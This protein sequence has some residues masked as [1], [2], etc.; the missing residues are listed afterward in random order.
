MTTDTDAALRAQLD[1]L[2]AHE[3]A[4]QRF[5]A[6][7]RAMDRLD[8]ELLAAQFWPDAEVDY[9]VFYKGVIG[10][11]LDVAMGFQGSMRDTQH[12][13]GNVLAQVEGAELAA[14]AYVQAHHVIATPEGN[15]QLLVGAR[16][17]S[18][19]QRRGDEWRIAY[20]TEVL[21]WGRWLPIADRWFDDNAE[22]PKGRRDRDDLSYRLGIRTAR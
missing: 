6:V 2:V 8:R 12:L 4:R 19:M 22:M 7:C 21:D 11:F 14:E 1:N 18:R 5:Y 16:Y 13:V 17:L 20:Q 3:A 15:V 9:G 10:G